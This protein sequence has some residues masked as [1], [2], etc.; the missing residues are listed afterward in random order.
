MLRRASLRR[1]R[2]LIVVELRALRHKRIRKCPDGFRTPALPAALRPSF[3]PPMLPPRRL[4]SIRPDTRAGK[5]V[6][7]VVEVAIQFSFPGPILVGTQWH[8]E[9]KQG[10][11]AP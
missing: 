9:M 5:V 3:L 2:A 1:P 7:I 6:Q 11:P 4:R 8:G 10:L